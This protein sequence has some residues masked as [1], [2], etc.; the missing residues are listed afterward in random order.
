MKDNPT[1]QIVREAMR[2]TSKDVRAPLCVRL[3]LVKKIYKMKKIK[4]VKISDDYFNG[5]HPNG[6]YE[7]YTVI[8]YMKDKPIKGERFVVYS[9][10][11]STSIVTE[12]LNEEGVFRTQYSTYKIDYL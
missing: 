9:S 1:K 2:L 3:G 8:G 4:L 7:G 10:M 12:E 11:F 6:I 5:K